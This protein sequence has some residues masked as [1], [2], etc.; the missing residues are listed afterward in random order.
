MTLT[1][2]LYHK[3]LEDSYGINNI[4]ILFRNNKIT[5][6]YIII[7]KDK[8]VDEIVLYPKGISYETEENYMWIDKCKMFEILEIWKNETQ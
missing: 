1:E 3:V 6:R 5:G 8:C 4:T 2:Q 7:S